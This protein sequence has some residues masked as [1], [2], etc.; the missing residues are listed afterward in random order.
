MD[1]RGI[2]VAVKQ[3]KVHVTSSAV[4][5]EASILRQLD[6]PGERVRLPYLL[7]HYSKSLILG[8]CGYA[9][10]ETKW[11]VGGGREER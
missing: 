9:S 3:F 7:D 4:Q 10:R 1:Y 5:S 11:C 6:H 2:A 8:D